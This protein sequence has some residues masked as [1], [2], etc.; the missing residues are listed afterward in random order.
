MIRVERRKAVSRVEV[1]EG[2]GD[3]FNRLQFQFGNYSAGRWGVV[4]QHSM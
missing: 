3:L 2:H 1:G 4:A